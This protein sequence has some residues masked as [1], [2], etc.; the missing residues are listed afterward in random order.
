MNYLYIIDASGYLYRSYHAIQH[1]TNE[2]GESTNA[3]YGFIRS[4]M[5]LLKDFDPKHAVAVFDGPKGIHKRMEIYPQYK[6]QRAAMPEDLRYQ[7]TWAQ[8]FCDLVGFPKLVIPGV[9]ADDAMGSIA[10][11][12][13]N[14]GCDVYLCTSDKDLCQLVNTHIFVL[15]THKDNLVIDTAAVISTF[16]VTPEKMTDYL[17]IIGDASDNIPGLSGFGP[18]TATT[19]L[20]E[21]GSL[22]AILKHPEKV[23]GKKKQETLKKEAEIARIA[24]RLVT[25]DTDV[26]FPK[27]PSFFSLSKPKDEKKLK[28]FYASMNFNTLLKEAEKRSRPE[29]KEIV[30]YTLVDD[31]KSFGRLLDYLNEQT[32]ICFD[33]ETTHPRPLEARL[34]GI[35]FCVEEKKAW[36]VPTNGKLGY[37]Q[38]ISSL[39]PLFE[40]DKIGFFGHNVKYDWHVLKN[41]G[42]TLQTISFDTILASYLLNSHI[43]QHSLD[44]LSLNTFGKVKISLHDLIGKGSK[45][46]TI[47]EVPLEKACAYCCEDVDYTLRLKH[48]FEKELKSRSL[49]RL[50]YDL[51]LPLLTVLAK[52]ERK[53][54]YIDVAS[55]NQLGQEITKSIDLLQQEIHAIAETPFNIKSPKQLGEILF[56][57]MGIHPPRKTKTGFS[58]DAEVLESLKDKYPIAEKVLTFRTVEKLRST[59]IETLPKEVYPRTHRVHPSFMQFVT[60]T[61]RLSCQDPNLQNIP[62]RSKIGREIRKAFRPQ[63]EGWSYL[64][65]D[66]S[67]IELRLLAHFSKDQELLRAFKNNEDI[68]SVTAASILGIPLDQVTKEQRYQAKAVNFGIIY[69]QQAFGLARELKISVDE[70]ANFIKKYFDRYPKI[71]AFLAACKEKTHKTGKAI[72]LLGRERAIPEISSKNMQIRG[73]AER[74]A[75]NTPLQGTSADL[76]KLAMLNIDKKLQKE[77]KLGYM[78]LQI[79]DSLIFELPDFEVNAVKALVKKE[80]EAVFPLAVPL[81]VDITIGKNWKEC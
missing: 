16:G 49:E 33:T 80:M 29:K 63:L 51:E 42:I 59:Y 75:V 8:Q 66:Y 15:N 68:H 81:V 39:K 55:L 12:A 60:A 70:A 43:R 18:K 23:S 53:G 35:G 25:L 34:V 77:Q 57:K 2:K 36:Y 41:C 79:H 24:L 73:L 72:T 52:M 17:A 58:T 74:L 13:S 7:I 76:I 28:E 54:I 38:V 32:E 3:L 20:K 27:E 6:A 47:A 14:K 56:K 45:A 5:K 19:L 30:S 69:G 10:K 64:S 46:I 31:Q 48:I 37:K 50:L 65:A 40:N 26:E 78:V 22:E 1:L 44:L 62:V 4:L 67:Q 9:E 61:G 11:W 71:V 21:F